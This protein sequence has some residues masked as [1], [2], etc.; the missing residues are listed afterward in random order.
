MP[1]TKLN[2][3]MLIDCYGGE[4]VGGGQIHVKYLT[5]FLE[6]EQNCKVKVFSQPRADMGSRLLWNLLVLHQVIQSHRVQK[7]ELIHAHAYSAGIAGKILSLILKIP[8]VYTVHGSNTLDLVAK[9]WAKKDWKY[10][11]EKWLLTGIKYDRQITVA[12]NFLSYP[13]INKNITV[14]EN[15]VEVGT[16]EKLQETGQKEQDKSS[17]SCHLQ[18]VT[19]IFVGRLEKIKGLDLLLRALAL[20]NQSLPSWKLKI[21]GEGPERTNLEKLAIDLQIMDKVSFLG[22]KTGDDLA[23]EYRQADLFV[24]PSLT[25]GQP[26]TLLEAWSYGLP[27]L[28]TKVGHNPWMVE[29]GMNGFLADAGSSA[30]LQKTLLKAIS[31]KEKWSKIGEKGYEKVKLNYTWE[32]IAQR[33]RN[34]YTEV[35]NN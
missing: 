11:L 28:V 18:P 24:L 19:F 26:L 10:Y 12:A 14:I 7:F 29:E 6:H 13:N 5:R 25:E 30:S 17:V 20:I 35:L 2:I 33:T 4:F 32:K 22:K 15:G 8:L 9:G 34:I 3:A 31:Y 21:V 16:R 27:V 1:K 23:K